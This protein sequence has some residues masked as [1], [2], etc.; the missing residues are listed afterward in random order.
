MK[1]SGMSELCPSACPSCGCDAIRSIGAIPPSSVFA[2]RELKQVLNGGGLW[3][4]EGCNLY[5]RWPRL[6][7]NK[8]DRLYE[9]GNSHAWHND[10]QT[11]ADWITAASWLQRD[12]YQEDGVLDIGCST[13]QFLSEV[14]G[15]G[16]REKY[17]I[18]INNAAA[19]AAQEKGVRILGSDIFDP[20]LKEWRKRAFSAVVAFDVI[21]HVENP[22]IFLKI[23]SDLLRPD[24][25]IIISTGN[26]AARTW[27][28]S[29]S[30]Y[31]YCTIPEHISFINEQWCRYAAD[32]L[33][34]RLTHIHRFSHTKAH[35]SKISRELALNGLYIMAPG[36][37]RALRRAGFGGQNARRYPEIADYPPSWMSAKDHLIV[38]FK[39]A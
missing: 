22:L 3:S 13:G 2:G 27:R 38:E 8:L 9:E 19:E 10:Q 12:S 15:G 29:G 21:E 28:W 5:F 26:T 24:G 16:F 33:N 32:K 4:C 17:G 39:Q 25:S 6:S 11:R 7:K 20:A 34:L 36:V 1:F 31:W 37:F 30:R 35:M 18:E 14:L 23:C